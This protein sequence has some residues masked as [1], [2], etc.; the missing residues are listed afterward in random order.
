MAMKPEVRELY[1]AALDVIEAMEREGANPVE[2]VADALH[3]LS[4]AVE[5]L[6]EKELANGSD[7]SV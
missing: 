5:E 3:R 6:Q 7:D 4:Q 1:F 2:P